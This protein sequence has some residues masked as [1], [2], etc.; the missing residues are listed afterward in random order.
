MNPVSENLINHCEF[1]QLHLSG[2][3]QSFGAL[4]RVETDNNFITHASEN[5]ADF[6]NVNAQEV[7]GKS[8]DILGWFNPKNLEN[9]PHELGKTTTLS[10]IATGSQDRIDALLIRGDGCILIE[11]EKNTK[12][13]V[14]AIQQLQ[15]PLLSAPQNEEELIRYHALLLSAFRDIIHFDCVMIYQ[16]L[17]D[18][19]GNVIAEAT[20]EGIGSYLGLHFPATDIPQIA[21]DLYLKNPSRLIQDAQADAVPILGIDATVH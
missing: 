3:I 16:F 7:I 6:S 13:E 18:W 9:L 4:L 2:A 11:L 20:S 8:L 14:I 15:R 21:R 1:E 19:S 10:H 5:L 12:I 17:E